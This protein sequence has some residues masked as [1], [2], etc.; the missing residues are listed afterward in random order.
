MK[1]YEAVMHETGVDP[2]YIF[3]SDIKIR[4]K[5]H[6]E[7]IKLEINWQMVGMTTCIAKRT[8]LR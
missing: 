1:L 2:E 8:Q 6:S 4:L 5:R 7:N 3:F